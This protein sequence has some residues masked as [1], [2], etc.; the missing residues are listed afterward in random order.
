MMKTKNHELKRLLTLAFGGALLAG[1][2][3]GCGTTAGCQTGYGA[4]AASQ[5]GSPS[6]ETTS[7]SLSDMSSPSLYAIAAGESEDAVVS[8][9]ELFRRYEP[10]GLTYDAAKDELRYQGKVVR[11]FEDYYTVGDN[12]QAGVDFFHENGVV[13]VYAIRDFS[14]PVRSEDGSFD[15]GGKLVGVKEFTAEEFAARDIE[16]IKNPPPVAAIAGN[17]PSEKDLEDMAKEYEAFGLTYDVKNNQWYLGD[18]KVRF[19]WDI[20]TSNGEEP[21]GGNFHGTIRSLESQTGTIDIYTIRDFSNPDAAGNGT[22]TGI[23]KFS[24]EEFDQRTQAAKEPQTSSGS[25][26]V[27]Q[28]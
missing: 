2:L 28:K 22:L 16:T 3:A 24:Q 13:D 17:P 19:L 11:W 9:E 8:Y 12:N 21:T 10:F 23:G 4:A 6:T 14:N 20:L 25:C 7:L 1:C 5:G 26:T 27:T 15:P 18:E